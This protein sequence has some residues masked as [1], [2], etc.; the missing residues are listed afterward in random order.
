M[1]VTVKLKFMFI[2]RFMIQ[3]YFQKTKYKNNQKV[4]D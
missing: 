1:I 3:I 4:S 2:N